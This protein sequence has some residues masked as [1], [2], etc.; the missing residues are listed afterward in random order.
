MVFDTEEE[1]KEAAQKITDGES[2][3]KLAESKGL[4]A[5]DVSLGSQTKAELPG[6]L[7][8]AAFAPTEPGMVDP[9]GTALGWSLLNIV[10][11]DPQKI[12]TFDEAKD[13]L[14]TELTT[15]E[16]RQIVP[17]KSVDLDD[18]IAGGSTLKEAAEQTGARYAE[19]VAID[20]TGRDPNGDRVADLPEDP[21][22]LA[23]LFD[24]DVSEDISLIEG[25][26]GDY[27]S[28]NVEEI[29]EAALRP[30]DTIKGQVSGAWEVAEREKALEALT[31]T[32]VEKLNGGTE[33]TDL[34]EELELEV[35]T[36]GPGTR[37]DRTLGLSTDLLADIF[38]AEEGN[39]LEGAAANNLT[40]VV[41]TLTEIVQATSEEDVTA[42]DRS[43]E[44]YAGRLSRDF[45]DQ[46]TRTARAR[47]PAQHN[48]QAID[49]VFTNP[50]YGG[51]Y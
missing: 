37:S 10:S 18:Q 9:V 44:A 13:D 34:A 5:Q 32:H 3:A 25:S 11:I 14:K 46:F 43:T 2:F 20:A 49:A 19:I 21:E 1:A 26:N 45:V 29:T 47:H 41:G 36:A 42:I 35:K 27:F 24:T 30:L 28:I 23:R 12:V 51:G 7:A 38:D 4:S 39:A 50:G 17:E 40:R 48:Q 16:A 22:F 8:E 6:A 31:A 33:L 15:T